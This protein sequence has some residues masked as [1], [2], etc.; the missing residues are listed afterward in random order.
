MHLTRFTDYSIRVLIF[1]A[2][3]GEERSTINEIAETFNISRNH[4]MKI[5]QELSQKN[6]VTAIRGKNGGL[7]LTRDPATIGLG[8]LVR[9]MENDMALV[10]CFHSD[11]AC[12]ITPACR[13]QPI[14]NDALSAFLDVLDRYTLADLLGSQQ[15]Q[16]AQ[17]MR[18]PTVSA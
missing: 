9:E 5:V 15:S 14:L 3:K 6:Y 10:E 13:L 7:L 8:E 16:L 12:I 18:I 2:A 17:L 4:L 11:N 1:L